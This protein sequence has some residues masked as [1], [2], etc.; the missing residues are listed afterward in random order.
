[1][2]NRKGVVMKKGFT[3][4]EILI[5]L[6]II[7]VVAAISITTVVQDYKKTE[8]VAR[9]K[10]AYSDISRILYQAAYYNGTPLTSVSLNTM[11]AQELFDRYWKPYLKNAKL[12]AHPVDCGY[13]ASL[14]DAPWKELGTDKN[15]SCNQRNAN[16]DIVAAIDV[17]H[18]DN[19][20]RMLFSYGSGVVVFYPMGAKHDAAD[21]EIRVRM[22]IFVV[23]I[24]GPKPPNR[25]GRD[26]FMFQID[27]KSKV[28]PYIGIGDNNNYKNDCVKGGAGYTCTAEI[29]KNGWA[30]KND[31]PW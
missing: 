24:N 29:I 20:T 7:G 3:L 25:V 15:L 21:T 26:V 30:I 1:M 23:D 9:L 28:Q 22:N 11:N 17:I 16:G 8:A 5:T 13:N 14:K 10:K 2:E 6:A 12:C 18:T 31:Y 19:N 4:A 27:D